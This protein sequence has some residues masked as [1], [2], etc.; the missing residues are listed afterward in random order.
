L[1]KATAAKTA[2]QTM[3]ILAGR[4]ITGEL[5]L[6]DLNEITKQQYGQ[7]ITIGDHVQ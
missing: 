5:L 1:A 7:P 6:I 4:N 3:K 2:Q